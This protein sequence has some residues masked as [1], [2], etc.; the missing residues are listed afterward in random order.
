MLATKN[1]K[2]LLQFVHTLG[3]REVYET[4]FTSCLLMKVKLD[5]IFQC[6]YNKKY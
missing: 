3:S 1:D 2:K 6:M 5:C 4:L